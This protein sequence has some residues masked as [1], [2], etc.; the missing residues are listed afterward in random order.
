MHVV[1]VTIIGRADRDDGAEPFWPTSSHLETVE[2]TPGDAHDPR[3][4]VAPELLS[5]PFQYFFDVVQFLLQVLIGED[6][7]GVAATAKVNTQTCVPV[8]GHIRVVNR[9]TDGGQITLTVG[10]HFQYGR[11]RVFYGGHRFP[12]PS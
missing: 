9:I 3:V 1:V 7:F 8:A 5:Q 6:T 2:A 10:D 11:H 12:Q 4:T